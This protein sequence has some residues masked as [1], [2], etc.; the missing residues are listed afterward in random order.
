M[1]QLKAL[2]PHFIR[3]I[4]NSYGQVFFS[5]DI[6]F[7][8][9][10]IL[11][12]FFDYNAGLCGLLSVITSNLAAY[13]IGFNRYNIKAG[14]YGFNSLLVG[15]GTGIFYTPSVEL[16][17]IVIFASLLTLFVTVMFEGVIGKY[18][19]PFLS[20]SFLVGI[21]MVTLATRE[22]RVLQLSERGVF[23]LN[24]LYALGGLPMVRIYNWASNLGMPEPVN[25]YFRSLGAIFF[26]YNLFAGVLIAVGLLIY[27]RI[28]FLLSLIG[29]FSAYL[30]F[31][32]TGGDFETLSYG[33]IGFNFIL[34]SIAVG[35]F[36]LVSSKYSFLWVILLTP[37][38][39]ISI[40]SAGDV[41]SLLQLPVYSLP[42]NFIVIVFLYML[43]F[44]ERFYNK[45]EV[46]VFQHYSPEKNL[47]IHV[48]Q[49]ARFSNLKYLNISLP[50]FGE[51]TVTQAHDQEPTHK[52]DWRFAW[53][54]EIE[55]ERKN[56]F[57]GTGTAKD[58]YY[59]YAKPVLA[60]ADGI[61]EEV[62]DHIEDNDIADMN[63]E[64]N[65]GNTVIIKHA[66]FFYSKLAHLKKESFRVKQGDAVKKGEIIALCGNSGRSPRP[67]VHFQLQ[68]TP[69]V[70]SRSLDYPLGYYIK[71]VHGKYNLK[72]FDKPE[73]DEVIQN[74][75]VNKSLFS[76]FHFIP[77]QKIRFL[78]QSNYAES[79][80]EIE[81]EVMTDIYN[82]AYI[83]DE[84]TRSKAYFRNDGIVHLFT[85][86]EGD[87][88]SFL[89]YF[90]LGAYKY[91]SAFYPGMVISDSYPLSVLK[92]SFL[93]I[94]QDFISPFYLLLKADFTMEQ[95]KFTDNFG[96]CSAIF[97]SR[98]SMKVFKSEFRK[99]DF[100]LTIN[101][102]A[103]GKF[104]ID[105][106]NRHYEAT[107]QS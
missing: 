103:I 42:F 48:N 51:W 56:V 106:G 59:C 36:F 83:N 65:W 23:L 35:G 53:D 72:S 71:N 2:F 34:T 74:L 58:D 75:T 33:Y 81:W 102:N 27:S 55:D 63:I 60:P 7:T 15:L 88:N 100:E 41:L 45:P 11:V 73:K 52:G 25:I 86:F 91:L 66:E 96:D 92:Y 105:D 47:Y 10:L 57:K 67:H 69:H 70:G 87:K 98:V 79:E 61:V 93:N 78:L 37:L 77:G 84:K 26:Q 95:T 39:E 16:F 38:I 82:N 22:F 99:I 21:W 32:L 107:M 46:V 28:S 76:A 17:V 80:K 89:F 14:Y 104:I 29:F 1:N 13:F 68:S 6:R 20:M 54:F 3:S 101:R 50:F 4:T 49:K 40:V 44:R 31:K 9:I 85:H 62:I 12:S 19:L 64:K 90:Y 24:D 5:N 8:L 94:I 30:F 43:K 18:G 97:R